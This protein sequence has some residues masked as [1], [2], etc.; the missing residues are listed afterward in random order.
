MCSYCTG[1]SS[2][3]QHANSCQHSYSLSKKTAQDLSDSEF[4]KL[5]FQKSKPSHGFQFALPTLRRAQGHQHVTVSS[6][7]ACQ[8]SQHHPAEITGLP[9]TA[10]SKAHLKQHKDF[11]WL[12]LD[13]GPVPRSTVDS[14]IAPSILRIRGNPSVLVPANRSMLHINNRWVDKIVSRT[15]GV[16]PFQLNAGDIIP[17]HH[18]VVFMLSHNAAEKTRRSIGA[19]G[20]LS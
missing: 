8:T 18:S 14:L 2:G 19:Y 7:V 9:A 20:V 5:R 12:R 6:V 13:F 3:L 16:P 17:Y 15:H 11:Y 4:L 1:S 10:W